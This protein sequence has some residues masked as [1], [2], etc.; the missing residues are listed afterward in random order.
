MNGDYQ[1]LGEEEMGYNC[2]MDTKF[3]LEKIR[4]FTR[5]GDYCTTL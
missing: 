3:Q 2:I 1:R 4:K 5:W